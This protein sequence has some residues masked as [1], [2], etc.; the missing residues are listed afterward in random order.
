[1]VGNGFMVMVTLI[2]L[3]RLFALVTVNTPEYVAAANPAAI[4]MDGMVLPLAT[5]L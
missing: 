5:K 1:M 2:V 4:G 3:E